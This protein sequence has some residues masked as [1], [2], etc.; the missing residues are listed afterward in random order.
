MDWSVWRGPVHALDFA[1][2]GQSDRVVGRCYFP[3][4]FLL[5][6]DEAL[7][8]L[9]G[10]AY[11]AGEGVGAYVALLLAGARPEA[12]PAA[13]LLPGCGLGCGGDGP[14]FERPPESI[15]AWE[16]RI[17]TTALGY[18]AS[19]DPDVATCEQRFRP[20]DY[21]SDFASKASRLL[22]SEAVDPEAAGAGSLAWW[23]TAK[24]SS[25]GESA[26]A[27]LAVALGQLAP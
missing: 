14:N 7:A 15:E 1:G 8:A 13:L 16:E 17:R 23:R 6:A 21:V 27:D 24:E 20:P 9:G 25:K 3:E 26:P 5:D 2:H 19:A 12:V 11:L 10:R 4:L 18:S 22:F